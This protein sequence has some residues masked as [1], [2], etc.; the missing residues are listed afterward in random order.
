MRRTDKISTGIIITVI[1][2][3][4][5][6]LIFGYFNSPKIV[7]IVNNDGVFCPIDIY[8]SYNSDIDFKIELS[9]KGSGG[10][11]MV[12][13]SS[14]ELLVKGVPSDTFDNSATRSWFVDSGEYQ[15]FDFDLLKNDSVLNVSI[16]GYFK[17]G[18]IFCQKQLF[19]CN[20]IKERED[21]SR[22]ELLNEKC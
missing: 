16:N 19:C 8:H 13:I 15:D 22:Y 21:S 10:N 2:A 9:N 1:S 17:C 12:A 6:T 14:S 5:I 7:K 4:I 20:Y 11:M 3:I 18:K